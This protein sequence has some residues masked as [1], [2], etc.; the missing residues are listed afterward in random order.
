MMN[1]PGTIGRFMAAVLLPIVIVKGLTWTAGLSVSSATGAS[2]F[3]AE[4]IEATL[5]N[6]RLDVSPASVAAAAHV[7]QLL[8]TPLAPRL[9]MHANPGHHNK[10]G[11]PLAMPIDPTSPTFELNAIATIS[12]RSYAVIDGQL[13]QQTQQIGQS[14]WHISRIDTRARA[15]TVVNRVSGAVWQCPVNGRAIA[16]NRSDTPVSPNVHLTPNPSKQ[17]STQ[18]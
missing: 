17:T 18:R 2:K 14:D 5:S 11:L 9:M 15:V 3:Q 16:R 12:S 13:Y 1:N 10:T 4:E 7:S 6:V 8:K